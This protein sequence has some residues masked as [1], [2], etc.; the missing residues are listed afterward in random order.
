MPTISNDHSELGCHGPNHLR[1]VRDRKRE[2]LFL[3][4]QVYSVSG[5]TLQSCQVM[6]HL[7]HR[8]NTTAYLLVLVPLLMA[9]PTV[10]QADLASEDTPTVTPYRPTV[11]TPAALSAPG[12]LEI[13]GGWITSGSGAD[14][15]QSTPYSLKLALSP[16][17]GIRIDGEAAV[18]AITT[19]GRTQLGAGDTSFTLKRRFSITDHSAFGLEAQVGAATAKPLFQTGSGHTDYTMNGI[20]SS[21]LSD[22]DH[23][24]LNYAVTRFGAAALTE[25]HEQSRWAAALSHSITGPW[26]MS[27]ELSGTRQLGANQTRQFLMAASYSPSRTVAWDFGLAR[28]L[29]TTSPHWS[30]FAG[31]TMLT[32]KLL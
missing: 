25:S 1:R 16:D 18:A 22:A 9:I 13:E 23:L 21:D 15:R 11:S 19:D 7:S 3:F 6:R 31:L 2:S 8:A 26:G 17:W 10:A 27:G 20:F 29:S 12:W 4:P 14:K 32:V 5:R 30:V 24:D 28:G